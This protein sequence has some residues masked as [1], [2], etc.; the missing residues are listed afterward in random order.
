M[1]EKNKIHQILLENI[2]KLLNFNIKN[3]DIN[4]L[5]SIYC[6]YRLIPRQKCYGDLLGD[7]PL[8]NEAHTDI[9]PPDNVIRLIQEKYELPDDLIWKSEGYHEISIYLVVAIL[10]DNDKLIENDM[11][12]LGYF[13]SSRSDYQTIDNMVFQIL[14]FEP[15]SE[16]QKDVTEELKNIYQFLLHW[17]PEYNLDNIMKNGL[18]PSHK[19]YY[20]QYPD[21]IYLLLPT[22]MEKIIK[23]GKVL[24]TYNGNKNNNGLYT[25]L[26]INLNNL[27]NSVRFY[28][29]PNSDIGV[30]TEQSININ[31][32]NILNKIKY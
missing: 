3:F 18:I 1:L 20:F 9:L 28:M 32:I 31:N 19:N 22:N 25:L 8:I 17:T 10:G 30:Y 27:D 26:K 15:N 2:N 6:D 24:C 5:K 11:G 16:L 13:L 4:K 21:R 23:L 14:Q 7:L 29:D 12:K